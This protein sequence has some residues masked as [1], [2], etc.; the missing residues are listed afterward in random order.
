MKANRDHRKPHRKL[1]TKLN[2]WPSG[3]E[4]R[5]RLFE[6]EV[7]KSGH[8]PRRREPRWW[9]GSQ[10]VDPVGSPLLTKSIAVSPCGYGDGAGAASG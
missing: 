4:L 8:G 2:R 6:A 9:A 3:R 5:R 1:E 7:A 10:T